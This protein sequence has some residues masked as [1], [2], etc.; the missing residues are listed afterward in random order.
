MSYK[1]WKRRDQRRRF[2]ERIEFWRQVRY[3]EADKAFKEWK[4]NWLKTK[5]SIGLV[6]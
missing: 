5:D 6:K 4:A 1:T 2:K 3:N